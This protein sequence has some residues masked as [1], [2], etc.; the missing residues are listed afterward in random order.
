MAHGV[1]EHCG[2]ASH[3]QHPRENTDSSEFSFFFFGVQP[4]V[5]AAV[6]TLEFT[7]LP[8]TPKLRLEGV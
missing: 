4:R 5:W 8:S 1:S 7:S 6:S 3:G 2:A